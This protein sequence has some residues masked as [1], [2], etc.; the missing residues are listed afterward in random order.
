MPF[1]PPELPAIASG[2]AIVLFPS[3]LQSGSCS[4]Y[5]NIRARQ[6]VTETENIEPSPHRGL[7]MYDYLTVQFNDFRYYRNILGWCI[8]RKQRLIPYPGIG[9][10]QPES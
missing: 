8:R 1:I 3:D 2:I 4:D 6:Q 9:Q 5:I 10:I 7:T